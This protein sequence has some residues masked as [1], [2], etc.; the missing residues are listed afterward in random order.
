MNL[1]IILNLYFN[2]S[3]V[4]LSTNESLDCNSFMV[5]ESN[6]AQEKAVRMSQSNNITVVQGPPGTGKTQTIQI[7]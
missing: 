2:F 4:K 1:Y 3:H 7:S 5:V 6:E